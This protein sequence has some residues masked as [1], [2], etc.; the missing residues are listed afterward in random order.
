MSPHNL[1][2][3]VSPLKYNRSVILLQILDES[4]KTI[5]EL[6]FE[7]GSSPFPEEENLRE[8]KHIKISDLKINFFPCSA[9]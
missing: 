3:S 7:P 1:M 8:S 9:W 6:H 2:H 5:G 4:L